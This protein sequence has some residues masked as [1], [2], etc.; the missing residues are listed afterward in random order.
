MVKSLTCPPSNKAGLELRR[1]TTPHTYVVNHRLVYS[2]CGGLSKFE[3]S[4]S[5]KFRPAGDAVKRHEDAHA[6]RTHAQIPLA[7]HL[8][9]TDSSICR[10][11]KHKTSS[12]DAAIRRI[13]TCTRRRIN[14]SNLLIFTD[15]NRVG[16]RQQSNHRGGLQPARQ[17]AS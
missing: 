9:P 15:E 16:D 1:Y 3:S 8:S 12:C 17:S 4:V 6:Q 14:K 11:R 10:E 2:F 5:S 13:H 7:R